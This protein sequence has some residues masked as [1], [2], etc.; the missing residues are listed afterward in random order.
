[1]DERLTCSCGLDITPRFEGDTGWL[2]H[3]VGGHEVTVTCSRK[4]G[5]YDCCSVVEGD[6]LELMKALP[7]GCVDAFVCDPPF[8][9]AGGISNGG[10]SQ[11]DTQFFSLWFKTVADLME[12]VTRND[13]CGFIYT[14]WRS[15]NVMADAFRPKQQ[16]Y[17]FWKFSQ[18]IHWDREMIGMGK[19]FRNQVEMIG[20]V[21][22]PKHQERCWVTNDTPNL[23]R[24][25][26]Y[27]GKHEFHPAEKSPSVTAQLIEW[28]SQEGDVILDPFIGSGTTAVACKQSGRHYLGFELDPIYHAIARKRIA[29]V[30]AQPN[31]FQP[32]AEQLNLSEGQVD[33]NS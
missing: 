17:D 21:R 1:V 13:G 33:G 32:K 7:D 10:S 20:F 14:D 23:I 2:F 8:A 15:V 9:M 6:C 3:M 29:A 11:V 18:V 24:S 16:T 4:I 12:R 27:Y 26:W 22:G 28:C 19:P 5:P 31:L 30:E 25:Y